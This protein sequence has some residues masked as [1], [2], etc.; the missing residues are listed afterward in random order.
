MQIT[1]GTSSLGF[2][3]NSSRFLVTCAR[4]TS[5]TL[6]TA[7]TMVS[8]CSAHRFSPSRCACVLCVASWLTTRHTCLLP[9]SAALYWPWWDQI[10]GTNKEWVEHE[11]KRELRLQ[12]KAE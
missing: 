5:I 8:Q 4:T 10:M 1:A 3:C 2:R 9:V 7:A 6:P 11:A 12:T